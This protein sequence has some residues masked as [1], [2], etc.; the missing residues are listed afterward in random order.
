MTPERQSIKG[1]ARLLK[2]TLTFSR[3]TSFLFLRASTPWSGTY[4]RWTAIGPK[5]DLPLLCADGD[6][7]RLSACGRHPLARLPCSDYSDRRGALSR[8]GPAWEH[9]GRPRHA[10]GRCAI[11]CT[12]RLIG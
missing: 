1:T 6:G 4:S 12:S 11:S 9:Q 7:A 5:V 2:K 10:A 8:R 3:W